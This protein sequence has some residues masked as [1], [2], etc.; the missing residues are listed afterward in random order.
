MYVCMYVCMCAYIY[1]YICIYIYIYIYIYIGGCSEDG[2]AVCTSPPCIPAYL[3]TCIPAYLHTCIPAYLHTCIPCIPACLHIHARTLAPTHTCRRTLTCMH[4]G[5]TR[6]CAY[7][8]WPD[9]H[10]EMCHFIKGSFLTDIC[11]H[12]VLQTAIISMCCLVDWISRALRLNGLHRSAGGEMHRTPQASI[13]NRTALS[14]ALVRQLK[15]HQRGVQW[16][17]GVVFYMM[18]YTS[19]SYSTTPIHFTPLPLHPPGMSTQ[20]HFCRLRR[21][22]SALPRTVSFSYYYH[23]YYYYYYYCY[24]HIYIYICICIFV[25]VYIYIYIYMYIYMYIYIYI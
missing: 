7:T 25:S 21:S 12:I 14:P 5:C 16:K 18:L 13:L 15:I 20:Q 23:Y 11:P 24:I 2:G 22:P 19:L 8:F 17:Q 3:H 1:I 10:N 9:V 4:A 6:L